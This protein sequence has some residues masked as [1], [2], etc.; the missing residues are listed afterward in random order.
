MNMARRADSILL[1]GM[2]GSGKS[3]VARS[4]HE[5]TGRRVVDLDRYIAEQSGRTVAEI[6]ETD[7]LGSF[8]QQEKVHLNQLLREGVTD[9]I[10]LGG[11]T[12]LDRDFRTMV[13]SRAYVC[14]LLGR[15]RTLMAR[16]MTDEGPR[17]PLLDVDEDE[18]ELKLT[19]ILDERRAAYLDVD[20]AVD[21]SDLSI[22]E[23][24]DCL[25]RLF[26]LRDVA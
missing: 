15:P 22:H 1:W 8:R 4:I 25:M 18:L 2:M 19:E 6:I 26:E 17:R 12:L 23:V 24:A 7:G 11:G 10:S 5:K 9:V 21:T 13:R 20:F 3:A 16:I 14:S